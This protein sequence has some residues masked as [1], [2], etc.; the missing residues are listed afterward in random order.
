M[1]KD[2]SGF[3]L[4]AMAL[5]R[6]MGDDRHIGLIMGDSSSN[7]E[8]DLTKIDRTNIF[9]IR[10]NRGLRD[11]TVNRPDFLMISDRQPYLQELEARRLEK[12][13]EDGVK[14]LLSTT[15][16]DRS[17]NCLRYDKKPPI[18]AR[19]VPRFDFYRWRVSTDR[20]CPPKFD[21]FGEELASFANV[22]GQML[23]AAVI[24]GAEVIGCIGIDLEWPKDKP[25]HFF[26]DGEK[27][28]CYEFG[29]LESTLEK[30]L[31]AKKLL[32]RRGI[33]VLNLSPWKNTP[34]SKVFGNSSFDAFVG[35]KA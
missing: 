21:T 9:T 15:I 14:L 24:L 11:E 2:R 29:S 8:L 7:N 4:T 6:I 27:E 32:R 22:A 19:P 31:K 23:Q 25:S 16:F 28:G 26:G 1:N 12:A 35:D 20:R 34:F 13:S 30:F 10:C 18:T 17:V 3:E 33:R 5:D